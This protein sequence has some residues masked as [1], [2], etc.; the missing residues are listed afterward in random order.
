MAGSSITYYQEL[1]KFYEIY[2]TS[3]KQCLYKI[4]VA[5]EVSSP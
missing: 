1:L 5:S 4:F 3:V 2:I